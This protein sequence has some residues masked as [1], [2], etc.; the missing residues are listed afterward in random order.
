MERPASNQLASSAETPVGK[1]PEGQSPLAKCAADD[2]WDRLDCLEANAAKIVRGQFQKFECA[3]RDAYE[4]GIIV[5]VLRDEKR[6]LLD[7]RCAALFLRRVLND[8]RAVWVLL[9]TGYTS[10][11]AAVAASLYENSLAVGC[12]AATESNIAKFLQSENGELPWSPMQMAKMTVESEGRE[13][14]TKDFENQWRALYAHYVWLCQIKHPTRQSVIHDTVGSKLP[15]ER[16]VVMALPNV[17]PE[18]VSVKAMVAIIALTRTVECIEAFARA[19]GFKDEMPS[20]YRL[21]ERLES[22]KRSYCLA[23]T[24]VK[25]DA[26]PISIRQS[27]FTGKFPPVA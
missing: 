20:D 2:A 19:L 15:C 17:K 14:G 12:L 1:Q 24:E 13:V 23:F 4:A 9:R 6:S 21:K 7:V 10:Q 26:N 3:F 5:P 11:A 25:N 27:W 18:D 22:A 16:Y 8:L